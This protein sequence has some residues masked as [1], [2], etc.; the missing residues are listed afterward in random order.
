MGAGAVHALAMAWM[1]AG[2]C[3]DIGAMQG[4]RGTE[5]ISS[6]PRQYDLSQV[7]PTVPAR[8]RA[9]GA[10]SSGSGPKA[11]GPV[12]KVLPLTRANNVSIMLTQV[13]A[14]AAGMGLPAL[15]CQDCLAEAN[16]QGHLQ[17]P[18]C[19]LEWQAFLWERLSLSD[20]LLMYGHVTLS[21]QHHAPPPNP[22]APAQFST[23][24]GFESIRTALL[25]GSDALGLDHLSLL[26]QVGVGGECRLL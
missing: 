20:S 24:P 23:F 10:G 11:T 12:V 7:H 25:T 21:H 6:P 22:S 1:P 15:A 18:H 26:M 17:R 4:G 19:S 2:G 5:P 3:L 9:G 16:R 8:G 14:R 13:P